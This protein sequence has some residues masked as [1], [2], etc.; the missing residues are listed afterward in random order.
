MKKIKLENILHSKGYV[1]IETL[2]VAGIIIASG[3]FLISKLAFKS[4]GISDKSNNS[5]TYGKTVL[6]NNNPNSGY[7]NVPSMIPPTDSKYFTVEDIDGGVE[8][9]GYSNKAPKDVVI[10]SEIDGKRVISIGYQAFWNKRLTSV[11]IPNTVKTI[12]KQ[13]FSCN[14]L[15][16]VNMPNSV[17]S[18]GYESFYDNQLTSITIP[19]SVTSIGTYAFQ[20][21]QLTSVTIP[22]SVT[23]IDRGAFVNNQLTSVTI[24]NSTN[25]NGNVFDNGVVVNRK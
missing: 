3:A 17:T 21:N 2:I 10:P 22:N 18:I 23:S 24:P 15:T 5:L 20:R 14:Q 12:G 9:T 13:S 25:L 1:S 19:N 7:G 11:T 8:I 4:K 6:D 16:K